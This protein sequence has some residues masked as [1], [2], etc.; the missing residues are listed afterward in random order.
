MRSRL[1]RALLFAA[2]SLLCGASFLTAAP[3]SRQLPARPTLDGELLRMADAIPGFGGLF[4]DRAGFATVYLTDP[5]SQAGALTAL[6]EVRILRGDYDFRQ[7]DQWRA[8]LRGILTLPGVV[9]L[10]VDE[11][12]NRVKIGVDRTQATRALD[13]VASE[14][15]ALGVPRAAVV[16][17]PVAPL[18]QL[19]TL[20]DRERPVRGGMQI[21]WLN[22]LCTLGFNANRGVAGFVTNSHCSGQQGGVQST[23]YFQN[24]NASGNRIG[25]ETADPLYFSGGFCPSGRI[26]RYSDSAFAAYDTPSLQGMGK[27]A[28][29]S[30]VGSLTVS[31][32][33]PFWNILGTADRP[34]AG[35]VLNKVGRTTGWT[36]GTVAATCV[37]V[38]VLNPNGS[39][40]NITQLCQDVVNA[41]VAS[42]DSGSPVFAAGTADSDT[43]AT[44]YGILWGGN[45]TQFIFSRW[46]NIVR[47]LGTLQVVRPATMVNGASFTP[48]VAP[49]SI[50]AIFGSGLATTTASASSQPLPTT[51]GGTRVTVRDASGNP[52]LASLLFVSPGQINL[53]LPASLAAG[54]TPVTVTAGDGTVSS[55]STAVS[56]TAPGLFAAN[57]NGV[58]VAAA[59]ILRVKADGSQIYEAVA[60]FDGTRWVPLPVDFGPTTDTLYLVLFGTGIR[61]R[62]SQ[63]SVSVRVGSESPTVLYAGP[64]G[65]FAGQDQVNVGPLPRSLA[66]GERNIVLTISNPS[67][68]SSNTVTVT[69]R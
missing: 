63:Q 26:C 37:D 35:Q 34:L 8:A 42:G 14:I 68:V 17:E 66:G 20:Q 41:G 10:D 52:V 46:E 30:A 11:T 5:S 18:R 21:A 27:I 3:D 28:R 67:P 43:G 16:I 33:A 22:S 62:P 45:G 69:F 56:N 57:S 29:P 40:S 44:L 25:V 12:R 48:A 1:L 36:R 31:T 23:I 38:N 24:V 4:Y 55:G 50:A 53:V 61:N 64:Q 58:G 6:G 32:T 39:L 65:Q 49:G 7:L 51:L 2:A 9:Q 60:Q 13:A 15:K 59:N 19:A 47:E 54:A